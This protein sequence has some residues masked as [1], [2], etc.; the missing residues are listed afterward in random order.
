[1]GRLGAYLFGLA[2]SMQNTHLRSLRIQFLCHPGGGSLL[3]AQLLNS[4]A[5]QGIAPLKPP[6]KGE[7]TH[8]DL[9]IASLLQIMFAVHPSGV[10]S[11][12]DL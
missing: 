3:Y 10:A 4:Q 11:E 9:R 2:Y 7:T 8:Y 5:T 1:M 12:R 6:P